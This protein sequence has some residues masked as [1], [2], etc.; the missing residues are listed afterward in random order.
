MATALQPDPRVPAH[1]TRMT[2]EEFLAL[3][4]DARVEL[5]DGVLHHMDQESDVSPARRPHGSVTTRLSLALAG[6]VVAHGLGEVFDSSTQYILR[7]DPPLILVPDLSFVDGTRLPE[8]VPEHD[9]ED[10]VFAPD[11]A[12]EVLSPSNTMSEINRKLAAYLGHGVR[13]VWVVDPPERSV[14]VYGT[15]PT[16]CWLGEADTLD[17]GDVVRG[18]STPVAAMF[19]GLRRRG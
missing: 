2:L 9:A 10:E 11:L 12:V 13:L 3:P 7:R 14:V 6:H 5:V 4:D 15:G 16:V 18:F 19:A 17:G 1:G 8:G